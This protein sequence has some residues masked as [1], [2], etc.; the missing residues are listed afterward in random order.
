MIKHKY[1]N[2]E[3]ETR[4]HYVY[5][6]YEENG[7]KYIGSRTCYDCSPEEDPYLGSYTDQSFRPTKKEILV[8]C[9]T[10][11]EANIIE[12]FLHHNHGVM[13]DDKYAN[14]ASTCFCHSLYGTDMFKDSI[15]CPFKS[16]GFNSDSL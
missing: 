7:R 15:S 11:D 10:R 4:T 14:R 16:C 5:L 3:Y 9:E 12:A 13:H 8:V 6:S 1:Y 2:F